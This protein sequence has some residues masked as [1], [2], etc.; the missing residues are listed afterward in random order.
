M[1]VRNEE[2]TMSFHSVALSDVMTRVN[3]STCEG[4]VGRGTQ[5]SLRPHYRCSV[6]AESRLE[7]TYLRPGA[8]PSW[9]NSL[10][11]ALVV[12]AR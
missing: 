11:K 3:L 12:E 7:G 10:T 8:G 4:G 6:G 9:S 2:R 1:V 5:L